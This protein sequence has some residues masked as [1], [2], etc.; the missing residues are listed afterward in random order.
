MN[1]VK[2]QCSVKAMKFIPFERSAL[3]LG[4]VPALIERLGDSS[5]LVYDFKIRT[6]TRPPCRR[7]L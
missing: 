4:L 2:S 3:R 7:S 1:F 5:A 6:I